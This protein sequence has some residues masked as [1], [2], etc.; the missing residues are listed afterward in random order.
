MALKKE[1]YWRSSLWHHFITSFGDW[2]GLLFIRAALLPAIFITA[3]LLLL[4]YYHFLAGLLPFP[5]FYLGLAGAVC[6]LAALVSARLRIPALT[7]FLRNCGGGLI[8]LAVLWLSVFRF[9]LAAFWL[10]PVD[11]IF[12]GGGSW[13]GS[14]YN[15]PCQTIARWLIGVKSLPVGGGSGTLPDYFSFFV[16]KPIQQDAIYWAIPAAVLGAVLVILLLYFS[17]VGCFFL[18]LLPAIVT[19]AFLRKGW[20]LLI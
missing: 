14:V 9:G 4:Q 19:Y 5:E 7:V 6:F 12:G 18:P 20:N 15:L 13:S 17:I 8:C 3:E 16:L 2:A 1:I 10:L 11:F